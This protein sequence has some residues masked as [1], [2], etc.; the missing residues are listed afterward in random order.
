ML[1]P[2]QE[3]AQVRP[4]PIRDRGIETDG[5]EGAVEGLHLLD[6]VAGERL[7]GAAH[8]CEDDAVAVFALNEAAEGATV[9][10]F[11]LVGAPA[12]LENAVGIEDVGEQ[13][14]RWLDL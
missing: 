7:F 10:G 6:G 14:L 13:P 1:L 12:G 11:D 9:L 4:L 2:E 8:H 5:H 3:G